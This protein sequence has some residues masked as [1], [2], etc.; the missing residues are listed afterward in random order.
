MIVTLIGSLD[1]KDWGTAFPKCQQLCTSVHGVTYQKTWN[2]KDHHHSV[3]TWHAAIVMVINNDHWHLFYIL[4]QVG[5]LLSG[6]STPHIR[7]PTIGGHCCKGTVHCINCPR[8]ALFKKW[9][10]LG[11]KWVY[12]STLLIWVNLQIL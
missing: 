12:R 4:R 10:I 3:Q 11:T 6:S 5:H 2:N 9:N 8:Y 1:A 7:R